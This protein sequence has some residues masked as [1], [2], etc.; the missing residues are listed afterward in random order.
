MTDSEFIAM[1][2]AVLERIGEALDASDAD[3]DWQL[4]DGILEIDCSDADGSG[5]KIIVNRHLPNREI[6][7]ATRGGG[8]HFRPADVGGW[9]D[10]R[11]ADDLATTLARAL[12]E[13]AGT[14]IRIAV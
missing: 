13:Q 3:I 7:L 12:A 2:D 5:G 6:W 11:G 9:R 10:T 8:F 14:S 4:N 1:T